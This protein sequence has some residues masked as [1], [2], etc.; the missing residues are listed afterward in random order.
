MLV[1]EVVRSPHCWGGRA[2]GPGGSSASSAQREGG[3]AGARTRR[4]LCECGTR[5]VAGWPFKPIAGAGH[6]AVRGPAARQ[7]APPCYRAHSPS[8]SRSASAR[9]IQLL[10]DWPTNASGLGSLRSE[11]AITAHCALPSRHHRARSRHAATSPPALPPR[12]LVRDV[13]AC[14]GEGAGLIT[15]CKIRLPPPGGFGNHH[16]H[17]AAPNTTVTLSP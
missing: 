1:T 5:P 8:A 14:G 11:A 7:G 3:R 17:V 10:Q 4:P 9:S 15:A 2:L 16:V 13:G 6:G 12:R